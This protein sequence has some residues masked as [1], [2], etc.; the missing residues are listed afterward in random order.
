MA[1][2]RLWDAPIERLDEFQQVKSQKRIKLNNTS[3]AI[4]LHERFDQLPSEASAINQGSDFHVV[5]NSANGTN[6]IS[7]SLFKEQIAAVGVRGSKIVRDDGYRYKSSMKGV[8][9][10]AP[11]YNRVNEGHY[12]NVANESRFGMHAVNEQSKTMFRG[13][14]PNTVGSSNHTRYGGFERH[15]LPEFYPRLPESL[16]ESMVT[17]NVPNK[18]S[19]RLNDVQIETAPQVF[20]TIGF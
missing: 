12:L 7:E 17:P 10:L 6:R 16:P 4:P 5:L 13:Q 2:F 9:K 8:A 18:D 19:V 3:H 15:S 20:P 11:K 14:D 1:K